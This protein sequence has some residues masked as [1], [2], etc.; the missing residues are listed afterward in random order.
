[1]TMVS[2]GRKRLPK[3]YRHIWP[4]PAQQHCQDLC[5]FCGLDCSG[6]KAKS[7]EAP[8]CGKCVP[9]EIM[10]SVISNITYLYHLVS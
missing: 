6:V 10:S 9:V 5:S 2:D 8:S 3:K 4:A 7:Y 1:M